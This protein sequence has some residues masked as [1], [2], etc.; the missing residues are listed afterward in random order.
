MH[1][2]QRF[3]LIIRLTFA[4]GYVSEQ[5]QLSEIILTANFCSITGKHTSPVTSMSLLVSGGLLL[6]SVS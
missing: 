3:T 5:Q 2:K 4:Q 6:F 1:Q